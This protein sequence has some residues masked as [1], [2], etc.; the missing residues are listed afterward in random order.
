MGRAR[1]TR[2]GKPL[3]TTRFHARCAAHIPHAA[4]LLRPLSPS[5]SQGHCSVGCG[6][7]WPMSEPCHRPMPGA[8]RDRAPAADGLPGRR[9]GALRPREPPA[10]PRS[11][12]PAWPARAPRKRTSRLLRTLGCLSPPLPPPHSWL[13]CAPAASAARRAAFRARCRRLLPPGPPMLATAACAVDPRLA[14][15]CQLPSLCALLMSSAYHLCTR[16]PNQ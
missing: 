6:E 9:H 10:A 13:P 4:L 3:C 1:R 11:C 15:T 7:L 2:R 16:R 5:S 12:A 8:C 14:M